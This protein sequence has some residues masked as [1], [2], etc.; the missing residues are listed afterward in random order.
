MEP[1][2]LRQLA[3]QVSHISYIL[4]IV[5]YSLSEANSDFEE[6]TPISVII[7]NDD[8]S[9]EVRLFTVSD[10]TT[11]EYEDR[12]LLR[13]NPAS[14]ALIPGLEGVNECVRDTAT[15]NIIDNDC[16]CIQNTT[17]RIDH[18]FSLQHCRLTL[19]RLTTPL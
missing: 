10:E 14:P 5:Q 1:S 19:E 2:Q 8:P 4:Y 7:N 6:L 12:V 18:C 15:V 3:L 17:F 9:T 13:F 16:K 11:L